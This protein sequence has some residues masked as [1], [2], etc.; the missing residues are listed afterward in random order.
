MSQLAGGKKKKTQ[1]EGEKNQPT[2]T[3]GVRK[4]QSLAFALMQEFWTLH[5]GDSREDGPQV[6]R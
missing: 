1:E 2:G 3:T 4:V 6:C 5:A